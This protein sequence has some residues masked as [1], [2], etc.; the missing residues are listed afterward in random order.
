MGAHKGEM[1]NSQLI[2]TMTRGAASFAEL[3]EWEQDVS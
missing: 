2:E 1:Q 3:R